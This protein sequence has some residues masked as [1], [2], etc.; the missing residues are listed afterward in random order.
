MSGAAAHGLRR[1]RDVSACGVRFAQRPVSVFRPGCLLVAC[2][3]VDGAFLRSLLSGSSRASGLLA[4]AFDAVVGAPG[5]SHHEGQRSMSVERPYLGFV[6][7]ARGLRWVGA[8]FSW[9]PRRWWVVAF[10]ACWYELPAGWCW[11]WGLEV[12]LGKRGPHVSKGSRWGR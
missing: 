4:L 10:H 5:P 11:H 8:K 3:L 7:R 9:S 6:S 1:S 2:E 12:W